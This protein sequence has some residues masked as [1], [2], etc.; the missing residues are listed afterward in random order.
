MEDFVKMLA[1]LSE[2]EW[3]LIVVVGLILILFRR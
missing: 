3:R 1:S 2:G